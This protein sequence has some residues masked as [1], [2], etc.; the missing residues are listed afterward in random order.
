MAKV[1]AFEVKA[2]WK[3]VDC[4]EVETSWQREKKREDL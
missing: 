1:H 3:N 4:V 2:Q